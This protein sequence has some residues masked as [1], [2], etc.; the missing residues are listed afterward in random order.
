VSRELREPDKSFYIYS[1]PK[2][3]NDSGNASASSAFASIFDTLS[4]YDFGWNVED[5]NGSFIRTDSTTKKG[6][7]MG[8]KGCNAVESSNTSPSLHA[9]RNCHYRSTVAGVTMQ[10]KLSC[11]LLM[12]LCMDIIMRQLLQLI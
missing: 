4:A 1:A 6:I 8:Q 10:P 2:I 9:L 5:N 7:I 11:I 3:D 12:A